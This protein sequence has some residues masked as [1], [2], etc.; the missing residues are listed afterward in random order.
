MYG[1]PHTFTQVSYNNNPLTRKQ[2]AYLEA[3]P[4]FYSGITGRDYLQVFQNKNRNFN[5]ES[6]CNIFNVPIDQIIDT[7]SSGM[8][9]KLSII[10]ILSLDKDII[11]LDEPFNSMDMESVSILQLTLK[12]LAKKGKTI[13]LT[14]H[15]LESLSTLCDT[16]SL[17]EKGQIA[18]TCLPR[19]FSYL[20]Q[21]LTKAIERDYNN[22]LDMVFSEAIM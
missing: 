13:I 3:S 7:Y 12:K 4:F 11:L 16:I 5:I 17:L 10:A 18:T 22:R 21:R 15:I 20:S 6:L 1:Y 2:I 19:D 8:K 9:K 14:S